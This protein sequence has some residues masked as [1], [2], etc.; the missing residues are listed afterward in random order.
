MN[1]QLINS[2]NIEFGLKKIKRNSMNERELL[3]EFIEWARDCGED[4]FYIF[5]NESDAIERF[6]ENRYN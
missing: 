1:V 6:L 3:E 4:A 2:N 5:E